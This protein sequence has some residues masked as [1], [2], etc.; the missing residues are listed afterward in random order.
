M[1]KLTPEQKEAQELVKDIEKSTNKLPDEDKNILDWSM[2]EL[3]AYVNLNIKGLSANKKIKFA[4]D[5]DKRIKEE[6]KKRD[7][8]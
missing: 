4:M 5:L 8:K 7:K 1:N 2:K 6:K 3:S